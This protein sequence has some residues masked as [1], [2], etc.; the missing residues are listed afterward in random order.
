M[1]VSEFCIHHASC[2]VQQNL[3]TI[4]NIPAA[5]YVPVCLPAMDANEN[6]ATSR[7]AMLY[8]EISWVRFNSLKR[9]V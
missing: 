8:V 5:F 6:N 7:E 3:T 1:S 2:F 9:Y 4:I